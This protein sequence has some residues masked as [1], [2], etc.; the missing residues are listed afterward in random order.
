MQN[1]AKCTS[2]GENGEIKNKYSLR[3]MLH[4]SWVPS[5]K[6]KNDDKQPK[7]YVGNQASEEGAEDEE[8]EWASTGAFDSPK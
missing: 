2:R 6:K 8:G 1:S 5:T 3:K 4:M 7:I